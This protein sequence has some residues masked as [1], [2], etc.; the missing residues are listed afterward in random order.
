MP[1]CVC[2]S[3]CRTHYNAF[4][5]LHFAAVCRRRRRQPVWLFVGALFTSSSIRSR[6]F[7]SNLYG[8]YAHRD[9]SE[10][11]RSVC[12]DRIKHKMSHTLSGTCAHN[13]HV[14]QCLCARVC[15][16]RSSRWLAGRSEINCSAHKTPM[17]T[18]VR[19]RIFRG[20]GFYVVL[21]DG[22]ERANERTGRS[23]GRLAVRSRRLVVV[24]V[25][26]VSQ[27]RR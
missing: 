8:T 2:V 4:F 9:M 16:T 19:S 21:R 17:T 6:A 10:M 5:S 27:S 23:V 1:A 11:Q 26:V 12:A 14:K 24:M 20:G 13:T 18:M 3:V 25:V 15:V 7:R 22:S